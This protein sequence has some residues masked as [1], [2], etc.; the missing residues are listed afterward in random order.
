MPARYS[1]YM[2]GAVFVLPRL[3]CLCCRLRCHTKSALPHVF[4]V[5][6]MANYPSPPV[7]SIP[8]DNGDED[9]EY[10]TRAVPAQARALKGK[11]PAQP[12]TVYPPPPTAGAYRPVAPPPAPAPAPLP[13]SPAP[14][15]SGVYV[16]PPGFMLVPVSAEMVTAVHA[17][18]GA[19]PGQ[20]AP[21]RRASAGSDAV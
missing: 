20:G 13:A 6:H 8:P 3:Y 1:W 4:A 12:G 7:A 14:A 16:P 11:A 21:L 15:A 17:A 5:Y 9:E 2:Q 18:E 19:A 10:G